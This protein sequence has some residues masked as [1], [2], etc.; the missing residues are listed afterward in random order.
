VCPSRWGGAAFFIEAIAIFAA[1]AAGIRVSTLTRRNLK[2]AAS[3]R[4][5]ETAGSRS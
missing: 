1:H 3:A 5:V 4:L 2:S